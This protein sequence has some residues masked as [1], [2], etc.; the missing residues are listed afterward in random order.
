M[1]KITIDGIE[2]EFETGESILQVADRIGIEIPRFCYH[3]DLRWAG[4]CRMC[5]VEVEKMPKLAISCA[6]VAA[7]GMVVYTKSPKVVK[8]VRGVLEFLLLNHPIDCPICDQA[9]ECFL[10][11]YY[12][13]YGLYDSR[14]PLND[15]VKKRKVL[16]LGD[17]IVLDT[18]RCVLCS[19]C[20]RFCED[21]T[22][23]NEFGFSNRGNRTEIGTFYDAVVDNP[24]A[25]N[26]VDICPVGAIT[27]KD[28]RFKCRVWFLN[29]TPSV[30]PTCSTGC[31]IYVESK[32]GLV[33]RLRPRYNA[34]VNKSWICDKGRMSY[35]LINDE[36]RLYQALEKS[37]SGFQEISY[38]SAVE[39]GAQKLKDIA[40]KYGNDKILAIASPKGTNEDLYLFKKFFSEVIRTPHISLGETDGV[41]NASVMEDKVLRR[42]DPNPNTVGAGLIGIKADDGKMTPERVADI[43]NKNGIKAL[44]LMSP[45]ILRDGATS[46][47]LRDAL[48]NV[49]AIIV[50]S[51]FVP[52][53]DMPAQIV[54]PSA[55]YAEADGT[56]T[57][58]AGRV[59]KIKSAIKR[60]ESVKSHSEI[61][62]DMIN[63]LGGDGKKLSAPAIFNELAGVVSAFSSIKFSDIGDTGVQ[64]KL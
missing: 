16:R 54:F 37:G 22:G 39:K 32:N 43:I 9:G 38:E 29:T 63:K 45:E 5:Q 56:F 50:H 41:N 18:E 12:M 36:G 59:Q 13:R 46:Q 3:K 6:T 58:Y 4:N 27:S 24:Y 20:V 15:K 64:L 35:K 25:G 31:N 19:R 26:L 44:Y 57:N 11:D 42:I 10:Q 61:F 21:V 1:P 33:Q 28:F 8:A 2:A 53:S 14:I 52:L 7:D 62:Q 47:P 51:M 34:D 55:S 48:K 49:D 40:S 30:C 17:M 23:S 60:K